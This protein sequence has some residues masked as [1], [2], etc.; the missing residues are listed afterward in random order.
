[1]HNS[2]NQ[3]FPIANECMMLQNDLVVKDP[4]KIQDRP[5]DFNVME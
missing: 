4:F 3:Y 1:M 2:V 5:I